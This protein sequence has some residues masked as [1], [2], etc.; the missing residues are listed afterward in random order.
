[1]GQVAGRGFPP[2]AGITWVRVPTAPSIPVRNQSYGYEEGEHG[3]LIPEP[4]PVAG[5]TGHGG[6][7]IGPGEYNPDIGATR[8][9]AKGV[10][11]SKSRSRRLN[12][13]LN[14]NAPDAGLYQ[15]DLSEDPSSRAYSTKYKQKPSA[16]FA[17]T[18]GRGGERVVTPQFSM[19]KA[20][21]DRPLAQTLRGR[22]E[23][24]PAASKAIAQ[25]RKRPGPGPGSYDPQSAFRADVCAMYFWF[26]CTASIDP[27]P[28]LCRGSQSDFSSLEAPSEGSKETIV[29]VSGG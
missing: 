3:E 20:T 16:A 7:T 19:K 27:L 8:R 23:G 12:A 22:H 13:S 28:S 25:A 10:S 18:V 4:P 11:W 17:S 24:R 29:H 6:D 15:P 26:C 5:Y 9:D 2:S 1:M 21:V 14:T